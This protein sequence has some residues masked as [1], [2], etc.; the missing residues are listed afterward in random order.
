M[1][2]PWVTTAP[3]LALLNVPPFL[4]SQIFFATTCLGTFAA[5]WLWTHYRKRA[6][7]KGPVRA[8]ALVNLWMALT[9]SLFTV[10]GL[11]PALV[12]FQPLV[13]MLEEIGTMGAFCIISWH[14]AESLPN[15][16]SRKAVRFTLRT[17]PA[18]F[19]GCW[20]LAATLGAR[21]PF[22]MTGVLL[23]LE[24]Q[25]FA[26]RAALLVPGCLYTGMLSLLILQAYL[27]ARIEA[28]EAS[29]QRR[30]VLFGLGCFLFFVSC[31]DHLAWSYV[32]S[33]G[34][35]STIA[36][37]A[38]PQI[39][40][41]N[42][43]WVLTGFVWVLGITIPRAEGTTDRRISA[44]KQLTRDIAELKAALNVGPSTRVPGRRT[45]V[46]HLRR[47]AEILALSPRE[48]IRTEK[49]LELV[50]V[51]ASQ[52]SK[53]SRYKVLSLA[54]THESLVDGLPERSPEK[55]RLREDP[56]PAALRPAALLTSR[57]PGRRLG[58]VPPWVQLACVAACD[59]R[60]LPLTLT[61]SVDPAV[62]CAYEIAR[63]QRYE[64]AF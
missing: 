18:V 34:T 24:P 43:L 46:A 55:Q 40:T 36:S 58:N 63:S 29:V 4:P 35:G 7:W 33:F 31:V 57:E 17:A 50:A 41:E 23:D 10:S 28:V 26:Y 54:A 27:V 12:R 61:S 8:A 49:V 48:V 25:A 42:T 32:Q 9:I 52:E 20:I 38:G 51:I 13:H 53:L 19:A 22:P 21:Y 15:V 5:V 6:L 3:S 59:L 64:R 1:N 47:A 16:V 44:H 56:L 62:L 37:L 30:L 2:P 45:A 60:I 11:V 39:A 14:A